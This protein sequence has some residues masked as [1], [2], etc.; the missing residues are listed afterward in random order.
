MIRG[1]RV[2]EAGRLLTEDSLVQVAVEK[3]VLH[4]QLMDRPGARSGD[5]EDDSDG[6]QLDN[7]AERLVVV[8]A[9]DD[10]DGGRLDN[11]ANPNGPQRR[12]NDHNRDP[13][14]PRRSLHATE[15]CKD[16]SARVTQG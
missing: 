16:K 10:S 14:F 5:A 9:C 8:D 13:T 6:G 3:G 2:D 1:G 7:R 15:P 4:V 12:A 11:R